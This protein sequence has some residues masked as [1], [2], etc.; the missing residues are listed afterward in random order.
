MSFISHIYAPDTLSREDEGFLV[1]WNLENFRCCVA[2]VATSPLTDGDSPDLDGLKKL[3]AQVSQC[4]ELKMISDSCSRSQ[5]PPTVLG[6]WVPKLLSSS[7]SSSSSSSTSSSSSSSPAIAVVSSVAHADGRQESSLRRNSFSNESM[8]QSDWV[9]EEEDAVDGD[10]DYIPCQM[11]QNQPIWITLTLSKDTMRPTLHS[12]YSVGCLYRTTS[13]FF[14]FSSPGNTD[15]LEQDPNCLISPES[16]SSP[17]N[18]DLEYTVSQINAAHDFKVVV[19]HCLLKSSKQSISPNSFSTAQGFTGGN[20]NSSIGG[21]DH[22]WQ[23]TKGALYG[24][25]LL[26]AWLWHS[27]SCLCLAGVSFTFS[28]LPA[29]LL[30]I[31]LLQ[32]VQSVYSL[33][34]ISFVTAYLNGRLI[35]SLSLLKSCERLA[36]SWSQPQYRRLILLQNIHSSIVF[37]YVFCSS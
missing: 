17:D 18:T 4:D 25:I 28:S 24:L 15:W 2:F 8:F 36:Q 11:Y 1:G 20:R 14:L 37:M 32:R 5:T 13:Y 33:S 35:N 31:H 30:Y 16:N 9:D 12:L 3:L 7:S 26:G 19:N 29:R 27:F 10:V 34:D 22:I 21:L 6:R 23:C